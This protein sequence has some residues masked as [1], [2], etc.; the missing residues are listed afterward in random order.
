MSNT[1]I[2]L[3]V[4]LEY[5]SANPRDFT[6]LGIGSCPHSPLKTLDDRWDQIIPKFVVD[7]IKKTDKSIRIINFD[8]QFKHKFEFLHQY[9]ES[10]RWNFDPSINFV[11]DQSEGFHVWRSD[12]FR[13]E[14]FMIDE[15]FNHQD[16]YNTNVH[17]THDWFLSKLIDVTLGF[18]NQ[19]VVQEY[20]GY[21]L[22][23]IFKHLFYE[24]KNK[25]LFKQ[26]ILFD[27]SYENDSGC[28]TDLTKYEPFYDSYG[29]FYNLTLFDDSDMIENIGV[30]DK[31]NDIV[32]KYFTRKYK[33][34]LNNI[35]V[36]YRKCLRNEGLMFGNSEYNDKSS[37]DE[38]MMV[39]QK[40]LNEKIDVFT[41][42]GLINDEK[43]KLIQQLFS[44]YKEYDVYD[45]YSKCN[46]II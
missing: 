44:K 26:K 13:V 28:M 24:S 38:I 40:K 37:P 31:I 18:K 10:N 42:L 7:L 35:H 12:D 6:Y 14:V 21:E 4:L 8:P 29:N 19:L 33:Q 17:E 39:L 45:W 5:F 20:T 3:N 23:N 36:D 16:R 15:S 43:C 32:K 2:I 41:V 9:F 22:R 25:N 11:Y 46:S 30:N 34:E 27:V 1:N